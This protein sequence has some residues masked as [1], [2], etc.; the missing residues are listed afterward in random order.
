MASLRNCI[1]YRFRR[2]KIKFTAVR[3]IL[4]QFS[5]CADSN[6]AFQ[7]PNNAKENEIFALNSLK[8]VFF[9][10]YNVYNTAIENNRKL[11]I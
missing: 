6:V 7:I 10:I 5:L 2:I 11:R 9:F 1:R 4:E 8:F 3:P